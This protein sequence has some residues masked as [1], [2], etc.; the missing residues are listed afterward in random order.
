MV[1]VKGRRGLLEPYKYWL[2][3]ATG[4]SV[5]FLTYFCIEWD[6]NIAIIKIASCRCTFSD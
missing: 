3:T 6:L 5:R 2:L 1:E 4:K